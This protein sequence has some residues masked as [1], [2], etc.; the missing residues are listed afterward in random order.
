MARSVPPSW[1][2]QMLHTSTRGPFVLLDRIPWIP[3]WFRA[4]HSILEKRNT[5]QTSGAEYLDF[6]CCYA[7]LLGVFRRYRR[8]SHKR[9]SMA[10]EDAKCH[11]GICH[12]VL[13]WKS[14]VA[15][16][17]FS[18]LCFERP[19]ISFTLSALRKMTL[20]NWQRFSL[21]CPSAVEIVDG[22]SLEKKPIPP[23]VLDW[24]GRLFLFSRGFMLVCVQNTLR[25]MPKMTDG[26]HE[27]LLLQASGRTNSANYNLKCSC[28][29][30]GMNA[31][32]RT[33]SLAPEDDF[34]L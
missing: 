11:P 24:G 21:G 3:G 17:E 6:A 18:S 30:R 25:R 8:V 27:R 29:E 26:C 13:E 28:L 31:E 16:V 2:S 5:D 23:D 32:R 10:T 22:P 1:K 4:S 14:P 34:F 7:G 15:L 20:L 9:S 33:P 12:C 19:L